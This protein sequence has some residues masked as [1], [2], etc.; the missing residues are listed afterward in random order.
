MHTY[1]EL[2]IEDLKGAGVTFESLIENYP[3]ELMRFK[4]SCDMGMTEI[5]LPDDCVGEHLLATVAEA[6]IALATTWPPQEAI[7]GITVPLLE[8]A[9][10]R[11]VKNDTHSCR[12]LRAVPLSHL[13]EV[14]CMAAV[15]LNSASLEFIPLDHQ[16]EAVRLDAVQRDGRVLKYIPS[17]NQSDA[18]RLAAVKEDGMTIKYI[19][20]DQQSET[21]RLAAVQRYGSALQYIPVANQSEAV[22]LAA[23]KR[24]GASLEF[25]PVEEQSEAVRLAAV[26]QNGY[27]LENIPI[28]Q[29]SEAVRLA[30]LKSSSDSIEFMPEDVGAKLIA[31]LKNHVSPIPW[32]SR[33]LIKPLSAA[34]YIVILYL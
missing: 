9:I 31:E 30:A 22:R 5:R 8:T 10:L 27:A 21:V 7:A 17:D 34:H 33:L 12:N 11:Y 25:I 14:V 29:Q 23:V 4:L 1:T 20:S 18:V 24:H 19:P 3:K 28:E 16:S 13:S 15:Q 32:V 26:K 2:A 6:W